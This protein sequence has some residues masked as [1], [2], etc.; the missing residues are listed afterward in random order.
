MNENFIDKVIDH[1]ESISGNYTSSNKRMQL[2]SILFEKLITAD[3]ST[4]ID[5]ATIT[6]K[7]H[8]NAVKLDGVLSIYSS[9]NYSKNVAL[10]IFALSL[11][12]ITTIYLAFLAYR[13]H[14][15]Q[16]VSLYCK[17]YMMTE[18][19]LMS[20]LDEFNDLLNKEKDEFINLVK[21][22]GV[23]FDSLKAKLNK[24]KLMIHQESHNDEH[25]Q[26]AP[27]AV[28]F[29]NQAIDELHSNIVSNTAKNDASVYTPKED[30]DQCTS[31]C[32]RPTKAK[33][34]SIW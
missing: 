32:S 34:E 27:Q 1:A 2:V 9:K 10:S 19:D 8:T 21:A 6:A 26:S 13:D 25:H 12:L 16:H 30:T 3:R 24:S 5:I 4:S 15:E 18:D 17:R 33:K 20:C 29:F 22:C 7:K 31:S 23:S 11:I 14:V 28:S